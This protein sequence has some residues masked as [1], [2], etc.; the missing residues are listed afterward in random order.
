MYTTCLYLHN[1]SLGH[2]RKYAMRHAENCEDPDFVREAMQT[3]GG[4][5][6]KA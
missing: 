3:G 6:L 1:V 5:V 2:V 4:Q